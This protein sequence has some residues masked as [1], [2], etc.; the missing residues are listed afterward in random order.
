MKAEQKKWDDYIDASYAMPRIDRAVGGNSPLTWRLYV[1]LVS[2]FHMSKKAALE[3]TVCE[4]LCLYTVK[5]EE[6]GRI[7][8]SH[9]NITNLWEQFER[10]KEEHRRNESN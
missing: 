8:V 1:S 7:Q 10:C 9:P 2:D 6:R 4:A 3:T 5:E